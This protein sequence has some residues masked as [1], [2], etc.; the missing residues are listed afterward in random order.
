MRSIITILVTAFLGILAVQS[1]AAQSPTATVEAALKNATIITAP[2]AQLASAV[3]ACVQADQNQ[4]PSY[5]AAVL[6]GGRADADAIAPSVVAAAIEG[7]AK[8]P[9][10]ILISEI[11]EAAIKATPDALL[12]IVKAAIGASPAYARFTIIRAAAAIS[13]NPDELLELNNT[14]SQVAAGSHDFKNYKDYKSV[15]DYK[16]FSDNSADPEL[17]D[18]LNQGKQISEITP[19]NND[20]HYVLWPPDIPLVSR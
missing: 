7:L 12:K 2:A 10:K 6:A 5:V 20:S 1:R 9:T 8:P 11:I 16:E 18:A 17:L 19:P 4:A 13:P 14:H 3:T 15:P